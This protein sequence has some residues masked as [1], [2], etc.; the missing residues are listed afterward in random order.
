MT[1]ICWIKHIKDRF[2]NY[3]GSNFLCVK[4]FLKELFA[5]KNVGGKVV[6]QIFGPKL[7]YNCAQ[8]QHCTICL[9]TPLPFQDW[10]NLKLFYELSW[11]WIVGYFQYLDLIVVDQ[12]QVAPTNLVDIEQYFHDINIV[13]LETISNQTNILNYYG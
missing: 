13:I 5:L 11:T 3:I 2:G 8:H 9:P 7:A 10:I 4:F 12:I 6:K 1:N